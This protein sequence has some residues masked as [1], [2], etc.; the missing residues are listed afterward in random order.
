LATD[1]V[2]VVTALPLDTVAVPNVFVPDANV[3]VPVPPAVMVAVSV[4]VLSIT[5][6][7]TEATTVV[8]VGV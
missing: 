1:A 7:F 5:T 8:V 6:G 4:V 3:T 2:T